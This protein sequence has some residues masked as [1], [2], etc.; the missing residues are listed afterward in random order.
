MTDSCLENLKGKDGLASCSDGQGRA[1]VT[2]LAA[3]PSRECRG[4][5]CKAISHEIGSCRDEGW[6]GAIL[7]SA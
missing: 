4:Q 6:L 3:C 5:E 2:A 7:N 1:A